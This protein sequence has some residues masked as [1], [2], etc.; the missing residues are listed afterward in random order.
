MN[1]SKTERVEVG[2]KSITRTL[3][4][5]RPALSLA[6]R[7]AT[8]P[9]AITREG[10]ECF[11]ESLTA[12]REEMSLSLDDFFV[13]RPA[14]TIDG[15]GIAVIQ[16]CGVL[17][18]DMPPIFEKLGN[19]TYETL[20]AELAECQSAQVRGVLLLVNSP[21]GST[22]GTVETWSA[23]AA[24]RA[25]GKPVLS[26]IGGTGCSAAYGIACQADFIYASPTSISANVGT[27]LT[28]Y[29]LSKLY[30]EMGVNVE[31]YASDPIKATFADDGVAT[32]EEQAAFVQDFIEQSANRFKSAVA[33]RRPAVSPDDLRGQWYWGA[34]AL[35]RGF[36]DYICT[37]QKALK[38][39]SSFAL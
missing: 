16:V 35:K 2:S 26:F 27:I 39:V 5:Q 21:G 30:A 23:I 33:E 32:N 22:G 34:E 15:N 11:L 31:V 20:R 36:V 25:M 24:V 29:D 38:D 12:I 14:M 7:L 18:P 4:I 1:I 9:L 37:P 6:S 13:P 28:R 8:F 19:T 17:A 3:A 10:I